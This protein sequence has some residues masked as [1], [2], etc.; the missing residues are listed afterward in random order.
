[1]LDIV[2]PQTM[3]SILPPVANET[4]TLVKD[5]ALVSSLPLYELMKVSRGQVNTTSSTLPF[6]LAALIYLTLTFVLSIVASR[7]EKKFS[8]YDAKEEW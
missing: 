5:T 3:K 4:I 6:L 8:K 1:M 2:L 7:V